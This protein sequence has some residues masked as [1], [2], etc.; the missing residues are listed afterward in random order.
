MKFRARVSVNT[1]SA[2]QSMDAR[3]SFS[4]RMLDALSERH[5]RMLDGDSKLF[6]RMGLNGERMVEKM[7]MERTF[8]IVKLSSKIDM[9]NEALAMIFSAAGLAVCAGILAF[10]ANK[11]AMHWEGVVRVMN[12][13]PRM[14]GQI[15][16]ENLNLMLSSKTGV[17][18]DHLFEEGI[19]FIRNYGVF[20]AALAAG[21]RVTLSIANYLDVFQQILVYNLAKKAP[22]RI[23]EE[24]MS[25]FRKYSRESIKEFVVDYVISWIP[26]PFLDVYRRVGAIKA[27]KRQLGIIREME[28][29]YSSGMEK[30]RGEQEA[31]SSCPS[32]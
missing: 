1:T 8:K 31:I 16:M 26:V 25:L 21:A 17:S 10:F 32:S 7:G 29:L 4:G 2:S 15:S 19:R 30:E 24:T 13:L 9:L 20:V 14:Q 12:E 28:E 27:E 11:I 5:V 3:A 18:P 6:R 23:R 22:A